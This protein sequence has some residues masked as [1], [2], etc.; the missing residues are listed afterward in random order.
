MNQLFSQPN[1]NILISTYLFESGLFYLAESLYKLLIREGHRVRFIPKVKYLREGTVFH[2]SYLA[3][4]NPADFEHLEMIKFSAE[5]SLEEQIYNTCVKHQIDTTISFETLMEKSNWI[6]HLKRRLDVEVIDVPM[7]EWVNKKFLEGKSYNLFDQIWCLTDQS[8]EIFKKYGYANAKRMSW[9]FVD[10]EIFFP[11]P[12]PFASPGIYFYHAASLNAEYSSK[13]TDLVLQVF[14]K[15]IQQN[16]EV[17]LWLTGKI[18][19]KNQLKTISK[20]PANIKV[21]GEVIERKKLGNVYNNVDCVVAPSFK[22]GLGLNLFEALACGCDLITTD[23]P[24]MNQ[25]QKAYLC[26]VDSFKQDGSLIPRAQINFDSLY[27]Q[28]LKVCERKT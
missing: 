7:I 28:V 14:E 11:D 18:V 1:K 27:Q 21:L 24:P 13:N 15:V 25:H 3:P 16:P 10:R 26:S 19:D 9:D 8:E 5:R 6:S 23:A 17:H 2:P 22:E 20:F 12:N 4:Q